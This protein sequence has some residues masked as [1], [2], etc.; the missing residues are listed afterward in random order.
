VS[1]AD[2][3]LFTTPMSAHVVWCQ[4][5]C[6]L[7]SFVSLCILHLGRLRFACEIVTGGT[8]RPC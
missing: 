3:P 4:H 8:A 7:E 6:V 5:S 2:V 1:I